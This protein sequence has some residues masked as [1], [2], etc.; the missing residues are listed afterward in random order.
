M[1]ALSIQTTLSQP[2]LTRYH[3]QVLGTLHRIA[4]LQKELSAMGTFDP[5]DNPWFKCLDRDLPKSIKSDEKDDTDSDDS[6]SDS[7]K[8]SKRKNKKRR[9]SISQMQKEQKKEEKDQLQQ[10]WTDSLTGAGPSVP[11]SQAA[12]AL[13]HL[14]NTAEKQSKEPVVLSLGEKVAIAAK[15][16]TAVKAVV[17]ANAGKGAS[18]DNL[19]G[20]PAPS[21][22]GNGTDVATL[23]LASPAAASSSASSLSSSSVSS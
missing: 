16:A 9:K 10:I 18:M 13:G 4:E 2:R 19:F 7:R 3:P 17:A 22:D 14:A 5:S 6:D 15:A 8:P 23:G 20:S 12:T 11:V 21:E 1:Y